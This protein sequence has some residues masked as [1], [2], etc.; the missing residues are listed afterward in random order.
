M[1]GRA[2]GAAATT[3][4]VEALDRGIPLEADGW[5]ERTSLRGLARSW[6]SSAT[7][8]RSPRT[9]RSTPEAG[10]TSCSR[11]AARAA[12]RREVREGDALA[13]RLAELAG[14]AE[15][16]ALPLRA[17]SCVDYLLRLETIP[18]NFGFKPHWPSAE[19]LDEGR[20]IAAWTQGGP[21]A[22]DGGAAAPT[23]TAA[24]C[25]R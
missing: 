17:R 19:A 18:A 10:A 15:A 22:L 8:S 25:E 11:R 5:G 14:F 9:R 1:A 3:L 21:A 2:P 13:A 23:S 6:S 16:L 24:W 7:S 20:E 4:L 12:A